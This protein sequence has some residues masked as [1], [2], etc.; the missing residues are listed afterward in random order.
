M[1]LSN[2]LT[3]I[4]DTDSSWGTSR[5]KVNDLTLPVSKIHFVAHTNEDNAGD[6]NIPPTNHWS[7]FME[8]SSSSSVRIEVAGDSTETMVIVE[9]RTCAFT[10]DHTHAE[11]VTVASGT[12]AATILALIIA[13]GRDKYRCTPVGEGCRFWLSTL[14]NDLARASVISSS[15]AQVVCESMTKYWPFPK[16]TSPTVRPIA[17]GTFI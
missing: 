1:D 16:G 13:N 5:F 7:L 11:A 8:S 10:N 4:R 9:S 15:S 17:E 12:T 3:H 14:A 6:G 2:I